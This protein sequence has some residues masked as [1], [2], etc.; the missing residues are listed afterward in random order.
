M[1]W[2]RAGETHLDGRWKLVASAAEYD[3][4]LFDTPHT[5]VRDLDDCE[6]TTRRSKSLGIHARSAIHPAQ[7]DRIHKA[8]A[9][10]PEEV[11]YAA[12]VIAAFKLA[13][14]NVVLLDG[15][16][17]EEPVVKRARRILQHA[18]PS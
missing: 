16:F 5:R 7:I 10:T 12:R 3:V 8:L 2:E 13:N 6:G 9:P 4:Q 11:A 1:D 15:E 17:V 14:G 18:I